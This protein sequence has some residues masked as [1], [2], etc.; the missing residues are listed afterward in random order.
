MVVQFRVLYMNTLW[1]VFAY[2][3]NL[4][5]ACL[6]SFSWNTSGFGIWGECCKNDHL[7][8][9]PKRKVM[10]GS[11]GIPGASSWR[12]DGEKCFQHETLSPV[13]HLQLRLCWMS[14][15]LHETKPD[16]TNCINAGGE[17]LEGSIYS[18]QQGRDWASA[19]GGHH[20]TSESCGWEDGMG[21]EYK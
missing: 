14:K 18:L 15:E 7:R 10:R 1:D 19:G 20:K 17:K 12:D 16:T 5:T 3:E 21:R 8:Q 13:P 6:P 4:V 2:R 11:I 9:F